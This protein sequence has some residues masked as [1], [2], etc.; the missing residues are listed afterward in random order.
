MKEYTVLMGKEQMECFDAVLKA[1]YQPSKENSDRLAKLQT[2]ATE[3]LIKSQKEK[4]IVF[5]AEWGQELF[6]FIAKISK[7]YF[8]VG[9][10][11]NGAFT[12]EVSWDSDNDDYLQIQFYKGQFNYQRSICGGYGGTE[13]IEENISR[14]RVLELL[15]PPINEPL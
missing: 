2:E 7:P 13:K 11:N 12:W 15:Y 14:E 9:K 8:L 3:R 4:E 10:D 1:Q 5:I 6:D